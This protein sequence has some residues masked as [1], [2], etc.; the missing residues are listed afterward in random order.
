MVVL[1]RAKKKH[2]R[3]RSP[4]D[5]ENGRNSSHSSNGTGSD[6][7]VQIQHADSIPERETNENDGALPNDNA[8][9]RPEEARAV[10]A[11]IHGEERQDSTSS[12]SSQNGP[13]MP[14]QD[15]LGFSV[16]AVVSEYSSS[17]VG[18]G[19][20]NTNQ[21]STSGS[22]S[23]GNTGSGTG[24]GSNQG[25]S[26][27]SGNDQGISSNGNGSSGS[28]NDAKGSGEETTGNSGE[29]NSGEGVNSDE[30]SSK[31]KEQSEYR[32]DPVYP[33]AHEVRELRAHAHLGAHAARER[34][35]M[36]K[37]RKRMNMRREYEEKVEQ[38]ME[39]SGSSREQDENTH[40]K[41]GRPVTLDKVLSFTKTAR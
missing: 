34:K 19:N 24:S 10:R 33:A 38:E 9:E 41:P 23:G 1:A 3:H 13:N 39:S 35:L 11:E 14:A 27:G 7:R 6:R 8:E 29:N 21:T 4:D 37:K 32:E 30:T 18:S 25:S 31:D 5:M 2:L 20:S 28:G 12:S 40:F 22:G 17:R 36:D 16:P 26:S 15:P